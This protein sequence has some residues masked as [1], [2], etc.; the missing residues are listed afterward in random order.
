[1][2]LREHMQRL[3]TDMQLYIR[4]YVL[5]YATLVQLDMYE[6]ALKFYGRHL[7]LSCTIHREEAEEGSSFATEQERREAIL[8]CDGWQ[9]S[10][11][12]FDNSSLF[13]KSTIEGRWSWKQVMDWFI[14]GDSDSEL[15]V[16][17]KKV[18]TSTELFDSSLEGTIGE[19]YLEWNY[20]DS[21]RLA[22]DV[23]AFGLPGSPSIEQLRKRDKHIEVNRQVE[24][25]KCKAMKLLKSLEK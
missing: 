12:T 2:K 24:K 14:E 4:K 15:D 25:L 7:L 22:E 18:Y 3:P 9:K 21:I 19:P 20:I 8:F 17:E 13:E 1:M 5:D 16:S 23:E 10:L 11:T 6:E